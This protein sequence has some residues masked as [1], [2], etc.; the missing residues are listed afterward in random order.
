MQE[1]GESDKW[2]S[3][4]AMVIST[5]RCRHQKSS[6]PG[7]WADGGPGLFRASVL[8]LVLSVVVTAHN[9]SSASS[10]STAQPQTSS[11]PASDAARRKAYTKFIE[12]H[13][14]RGNHRWKEAI[15]A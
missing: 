15:E 9:S 8:L 14:L 1:G 3:Q 6:E 4:Q 7:K 5:V 12:A 10:L 2:S 11:Q 13:N